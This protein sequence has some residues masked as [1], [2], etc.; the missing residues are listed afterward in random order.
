MEGL[1][2]ESQVKYLYMLMTLICYGD[3]TGTIW[4]NRKFPAD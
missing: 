1:E 3:N 2:V 4:N